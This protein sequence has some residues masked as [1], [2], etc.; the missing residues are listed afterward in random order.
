MS[1][2]EIYF[3]VYSRVCSSEENL[4]AT[5]H[6]QE[7]NR[8]K[9]LNQLAPKFKYLDVRRDFI[10][11]KIG[12]DEV[13]SG[14]TR[15][16]VLDF[17]FN[18]WLSNLLKKFITHQGSYLIILDSSLAIPDVFV[19]RIIKTLK[20]AANIYELISIWP[21]A[22]FDTDEGSD[23]YN[24]RK[25]E[26]PVSEIGFAISLPAAEQLLNSLEKN[27]NSSFK[28]HLTE[29]SYYCGSISE[30]DSD[31]PWVFTNIWQSQVASYSS[32]SSLVETIEDSHTSSP[33][34]NVV[35][36]L[37]VEVFISHWY[38]TWNSIDPILKSCKS[39]GY[40]TTVINTTEIA[41][42]G[43]E[44]NCPIAFFNQLERACKIFD[45][46]NNF[47]LFIT[48]DISS[49][50]L[51]EVFNSAHKVLNVGQIGT[52][53]PALSW[54][55]AQD[56]KFNNAFF[57]D[58]RP[59]AIVPVNDLIFLY[60]SREVVQL[61]VDFFAF[62]R[63]HPKTFEPRVGWG[64]DRLI[65]FLVYENG[66]VSIRDRGMVL[67]HP[68]ARSYGEDIAGS[69]MGVIQEIY[70][71]YLESIG[72]NSRPYYAHNYLASLNLTDQI[73]KIR[74]FLF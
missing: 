15:A 50:D 24:L 30:S 13:R 26:E 48:A 72:V 65:M 43:W 67:I 61:M 33:I 8:G 41:R 5:R 37:D 66:Q 28:A 39:F 60:I 58:N 73:K 27:P 20:S 38:S 59:L 19:N 71:D 10:F 45:N 51:A 32:E 29:N 53:S 9:I 47:M 2:D 63:N 21:V 49:D 34:E 64:L 17:L 55:W 56:S 35:T 74:E 70:H 12:I 4:I 7:I 1:S 6:S 52:Y 44:N 62:Y 31:R 16:E 3:S 22:K 54:V 18:D 23:V 14:K 11:S 36:A 25:C 69:E 40:K 57:D 46:K 42:E 68:T